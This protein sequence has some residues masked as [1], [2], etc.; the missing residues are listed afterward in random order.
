MVLTCEALRLLYLFCKAQVAFKEIHFEVN[1]MGTRKHTICHFKMHEFNF[2][3]HSSKQP[4]YYS[5]DE[6]KMCVCVCVC[7]WGGVKELGWEDGERKRR[8]ER[9]MRIT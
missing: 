4:R 7:F 9:R 6:K 5:R 1:Q 3:F 8:T 2:Y